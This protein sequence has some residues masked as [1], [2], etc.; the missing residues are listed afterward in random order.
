MKIRYPLAAS[1][2]SV[3]VLGGLTMFLN[4]YLGGIMMIAGIAVLII[5]A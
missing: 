3:L 5:V 4:L 1:G 2:M